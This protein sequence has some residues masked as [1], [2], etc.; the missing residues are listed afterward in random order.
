MNDHGGLESSDQLKFQLS[1]RLLYVYFRGF[2]YFGT[3]A[4]FGHRRRDGVASDWALAASVRFQPPALGDLEPLR[5]LP[6]A[7][8]IRISLHNSDLVLSSRN[9]SRYCNYF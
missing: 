5:P 6:L 1:A 4:F 9:F 8:M 2:Q 7:P 3:P